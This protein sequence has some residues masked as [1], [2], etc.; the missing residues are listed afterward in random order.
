MDLNFTE[1]MNVEGTP[2]R[3]AALS[4]TTPVRIYN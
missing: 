1:L 2:E 3:E 4:A